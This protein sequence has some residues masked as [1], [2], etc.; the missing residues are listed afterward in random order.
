MSSS[1][2]VYSSESGRIC[3]RCGQPDSECR[4]GAGAT[5]SVPARITAK[6][7]LESKGRGGKTVTVVFG[8]PRNEAFL[9]GLCGELKKACGSGGTVA[10]DGVEIQG[11]HRDRLRTLLVARGWT[12]K[13]G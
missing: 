2:L 10:D 7:R 12:V 9:K 1:R 5:E 6:L 13:G 4:C 3:G 8:L 11:D